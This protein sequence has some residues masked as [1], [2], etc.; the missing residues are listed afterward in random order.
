MILKDLI[1]ILRDFYQA[2]VEAGGRHKEA[3]RPENQAREASDGPRLKPSKGSIATLCR[4]ELKRRM[5]VVLVE[6]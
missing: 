1:R 2:P 5:V 6:L 3:C 4:L